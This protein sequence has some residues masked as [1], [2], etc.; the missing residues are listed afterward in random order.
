MSASA[1]RDNNVM[2][3]KPVEINLYADEGTPAYI[4][5]NNKES[6]IIFGHNTQVELLDIRLDRSR[7]PWQYVAD[8]RLRYD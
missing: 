2:T 8:C 7:I 4:T 6:E 5:T 1:V 3:R